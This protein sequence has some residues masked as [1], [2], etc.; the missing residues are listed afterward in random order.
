MALDPNKLKAN[1]KNLLIEKAET[2]DD[3][4]QNWVDAYV[5]YA[6]DALGFIYSPTIPAS[7][8][9]AM[10]SSLETAFSNI[11][12]VPPPTAA[13]AMA[14]AIANALTVF[15]LTPP[16][17]FSLVP[18]VAVSLVAGTAALIIALTAIFIVVGGTEDS[19]A[20]E[21]SSAIDTFTKLV[22]VTNATLPVTTTTLV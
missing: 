13:I 4:A 16:I 17:V 2:Y 11:S 1:I 12:D 15:W 5:D 14:T 7:A 8:K 9:T 3:A 19:K 10:K 22:W 6:G 21:I 18:P 20:Q